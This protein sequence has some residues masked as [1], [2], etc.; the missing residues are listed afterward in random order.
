[1]M[2]GMAT[3]HRSPAG[4]PVVTPEPAA[5]DVASVMATDAGTG[6]AALD[7]LGQTGSL[8][9][10]LR[11]ADGSHRAL[12]VSRDH[13]CWAVEPPASIPSGTQS[14]LCLASFQRCDRYVAAQDRRAAGLATDHIPARL[15][16]TPRFAIPVDPLPVVVDVRASGRDQGPAA[17]L[18]SDAMR[19]RLPLVAVAAG[20]IAVAVLGLAAVLGG[21]AGRPAP[22]QPTTAA[23]AAG[24]PTLEATAPPSAAPRPTPLPTVAGTAAAATHDSVT[25]QAEPTPTDY[26]VEIARTYLV[27]EGDTYRTLAKRF[28]VKP[29]DLRA[30]NGPLRVGE[31][32]VVP[33]APWVTDAPEG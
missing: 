3:D 30:L 11:T 21:L 15:V 24:S 33:V 5:P 9:P 17:P 32:I 10:Y 1:M 12:G 20:G 14:G 6:T 4:T 27:K 7:A 8:C 23:V 2:P 18:T 16:T 28:G 29:R 26:P 22:T 19:R 25:P 13:R 31:R